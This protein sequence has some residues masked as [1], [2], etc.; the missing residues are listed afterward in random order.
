M[1]FSQ[2]ME[3]SQGQRSYI[4][5]LYIYIWRYIYSNI[6]K[7][8]M[9]SDFISTRTDNIEHWW[10]SLANVAAW[11]ATVV[12]LATMVD[13]TPRYRWVIFTHHFCVTPIGDMTFLNIKNMANMSEGYL[14]CH[15]SQWSITSKMLGGCAHPLSWDPI[16]R[17]MHTV[18]KQHPTN[19]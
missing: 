14:L 10:V 12:D 19:L 9:L 7:W 16:Q 11:R 1:L 17:W 13:F 8:R 5:I 3:F 4:Y 15:Q 18:L 6:Y 2:D